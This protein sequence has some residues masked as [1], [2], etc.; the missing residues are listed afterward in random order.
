MPP[1]KSKAQQRLA[2][3]SL[4]SKTDM[5]K[6]VASELIEATPKERFKKLKEKVRKSK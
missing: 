5:P 2:F 3:A 1:L 4:K 6:K